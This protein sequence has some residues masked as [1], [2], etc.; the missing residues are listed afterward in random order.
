MS[1]PVIEAR[2]LTKVFANGVAAVKD[3][4]LAVERGSV[5]GLIGRNAAGK[6]T[7]LRLLLGLLHPNQGQARVLGHSFWQA[8]RSVRRCVAYVSQ[9]QRL[10]GRMTLEELCRSLRRINARWD[11][12]HGRALARRWALPWARAIGSLSDG[13]EAIEVGGMVDAAAVGADGV[14]GVVIAH[15][16]EDVGPI[17]CAAK[18]MA[19]A[20]RADQNDS[21]FMPRLCGI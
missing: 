17:L 1:Q 19:P 14:G 15:D 6:T 13:D 2:G 9:T 21:V 20:S 7:A 8:P 5:Y 10:P 4:D 11:F 3:L 16:E 12:D 18:V